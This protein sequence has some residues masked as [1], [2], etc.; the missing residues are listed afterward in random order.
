[1]R[2]QVTTG[3]LID[4]SLPLIAPADAEI[5]AAVFGWNLPE[6]PAAA[7]AAATDVSP[8]VVTLPGALGWHARLRSD[9]LAAP[10]V[11]R[12]AEDEVTQI[13][14]LPAIVSGHIARPGQ[15]ARLQ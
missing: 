2:M 3:P 15:I 7:V 9:A 13:E 14:Q 6:N 10:A 4:H 11:L 12:A 8:A 5:E 1:Y